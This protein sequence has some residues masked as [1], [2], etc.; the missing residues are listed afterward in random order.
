VG[1]AKFSGAASSRRKRAGEGKAGSTAHSFLHQAPRS[2][3]TMPVGGHVKM[4]AFSL[5]TNAGF[6]ETSGV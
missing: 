5:T 3:A 4:P 2:R 6:T 1:R